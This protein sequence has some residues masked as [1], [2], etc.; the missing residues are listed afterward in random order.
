MQTIPYFL[1][2]YGITDRGQ[3]FIDAHPD[4][5][6]ANARNLLNSNFNYIQQTNNNLLEQI[7]KTNSQ[8]AGIDAKIITTNNAIAANSAKIVENSTQLQTIQKEFQMLKDEIK[9]LNIS[10]KEHTNAIGEYKTKFESLA[11]KIGVV[12]SFIPKFVKET[13]MMFIRLITGIKTNTLDNL[14]QL[15]YAANALDLV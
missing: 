5:Y 7:T 1:S 6:A 9:I 11:H 8:L 3:W 10:I 12:I 2:S 15:E 13:S 14:G 4:P